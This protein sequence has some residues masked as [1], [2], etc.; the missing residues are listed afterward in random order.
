MFE[1]HPFLSTNLRF[2]NWPS[3]SK[4]EIFNLAKIWVRKVD[5]VSQNHTH[6][7]RQLLKQKKKI[8]TGLW[9]DLLA[10]GK[11]SVELRTRASS[12]GNKLV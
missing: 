3:Q 12:L 4:M 6:L 7:G 5:E 2:R 11:Y 9:N 8:A 10:S 1:S